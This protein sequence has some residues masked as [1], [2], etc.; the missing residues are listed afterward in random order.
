MAHLTREEL[1][2]LRKYKNE[3]TNMPNREALI[4]YHQ[5]TYTPW[6]LVDKPKEKK[7]DKNDGYERLG[8]GYKGFMMAHLLKPSHSGLTVDELEKAQLARANKI[9]YQ[10]GLGAAEQYLSQK[11]NPYK[12]DSELSNSEGLVVINKNGKP[13]MAFRGTDKFNLDDIKTD[14]SILVGREGE[15]QQF[16]SADNQIQAVKEKYGMLPEHYTGFS[17]GGSKSLHF[18]QKY[19]TPST[20]L[21]PFM[22]HNLTK[23]IS[24][25]NEI[26]KVIRTTEDPVS[27]GLALSDN[28]THPSWRIKSVLPL[29]KNSLNPIESHNL[30]NFTNEDMLERSSGNALNYMAKN[31]D[32]GRKQAEYEDLDRAI[33]AVDEGKTYSEWLRNDQTSVNDTYVKSDGSIGLKGARHNPEGRGMRAWHDAGGSFTGEEAVYINS[34][35]AGKIPPTPR[36]TV[37]SKEMIGG[38]DMAQGVPN[39]GP[40]EPKTQ[41]IQSKFRSDKFSSPVLPETKLKMLMAKGGMPAI[42][43]DGTITGIYGEQKFIEPEKRADYNRMRDLFNKASGITQD[44]QFQQNISSRMKKLTDTDKP[45]QM[46]EGELNTRNDMIDSAIKKA[47]SNTTGGLSQEERDM[48]VDED[49][50]DRQNIIEDNRQEMNESNTRADTLLEPMEASGLRE[51]ITRAGHPTNLVVGLLAGSATEKISKYTG[52]DKMPLVPKDLSK[53]AIMGGIT[54][55]LSSGLT[56][57]AMTR[58]S[59]LTNV[60]AG[61]ASYLVSDVVGIGAKAGLEK[62]GA[63]KE[64]VDL[65]SKLLS[66]AA[67]GATYGAFLGGAEGAAIGG[68]IGIVGGAADYGLEKLGASSKTGKT[69]EESVDVALAGAG[70]GATIGSVVPGVGTGIGALIGGGIA[71]GG[72]WLHKLF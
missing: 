66:S 6:Q 61:A 49:T 15:T 69:A 64:G 10:D 14:A 32:I 20:S 44:L 40:P 17:L 53:G 41:K 52:I 21:N 3:I 24:T 46:S 28:A 30:D 43:E 55:K 2:I 16:K 60:G 54:E 11:K 29:K 31:I 65:G 36:E 38:G 18:G 33:K 71:E 25:T 13:E 8:Q 50:Q 67:G 62:L 68:G 1:S 34:L 35:M 51:E 23:N 26:Q 37:V 58:K 42:K 22:G 27:L 12:I 19:N 63:G 48:F 57:A 5:E 56:G 59:I 9:Y 72:Y 39:I 47:H 70:I 7:K 45:P 4:Q